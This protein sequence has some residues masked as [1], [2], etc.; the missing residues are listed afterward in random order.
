[1]KAAD[2]RKSSLPE[3]DPGRMLN[4][5]AAVTRK[6]SRKRS[7][8]EKR[9]NRGPSQQS[10]YDRSSPVS[11]NHADPASTMP[12]AYNFGN[13]TSVSNVVA[14]GS[15]ATSRPIPM[16]KKRPSNRRKGALQRALS[17]KS[18]RDISREQ[19]I[20]ALS[21]SV[22]SNFS[23][24]GLLGYL[25]SDVRPSPSRLA[26]HHPSNHSLPLQPS[27]RSSISDASDSYAY[28]VNGLALLAPRPT[29]K[30][31]EVSRSGTPSS[32]AGS[33]YPIHKDS[34]SP[35]DEDDFH[36]NERI[37]DL[38]DD[39]DAS[40]LRAVME[41]HQRRKEKK[42]EKRRRRQEQQ[43]QS[44]WRGAKGALT[45]EDPM[46]ERRGRDR[47]PSP[48]TSALQHSANPQIGSSEV[49]VN[50]QAHSGS[51]LRGPSAESELRSHRLSEIS[52]H[53]HVIGNI[54]D[55]SI[56]NGKVGQQQDPVLSRDQVSSGP[57]STDMGT[58]QQTQ[59]DPRSSIVLDEKR[60]SVASNGSR[61]SG[62][63]RSF[64][65]RPS[66]RKKSPAGEFN[67]EKVTNT[68]ME[69]FSRVSPVPPAPTAAIPIPGRS[70][71]RTGGT[72]HRPKSKFT[73]H[74]GDEPLSPPDSRMNS[75]VPP[76]L[77]P[78]EGMSR[79]ASS[80]PLSWDAGSRATRPDSAMLSQ[81]L[82]SID[83]EGSWMSGRFLRQ[84]SQQA[85]SQPGLNRRQLDKY[86]EAPEEE[87]LDNGHAR[88]IIRLGK[89]FDDADESYAHE[90]R[91]SSTTTNS[92]G[93]DNDDSSSL[94]DDDKEAAETWHHEGLARRPTLVRAAHLR[95]KSREGLVNHVN[96][97]D[98]T[99]EEPGA[100]EEEGEERR[101]RY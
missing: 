64:F 72:I 92:R 8:R 9:N 24:S 23:R 3:S 38:A 25:P 56:R 7:K 73:E 30:C 42:K 81:S 99:E 11:M 21:S 5:I 35:Y 22:P 94:G 63:L 27:A 32:F 100:E 95:A 80:R 15:F 54:D 40:G 18:S 85:S 82:A 101:R 87:D 77:D 37:A 48:A 79:E 41:R 78:Y 20:K 59:T 84:I 67:S 98:T 52:A 28:K 47:T 46:D 55:R 53:A 71:H 83:S 45:P 61:T 96:A 4:P 36:S 26:Q 14:E 1:M 65:R 39:L 19:Q 68:S 6:P 31:A 10:N 91:A 17:R 70:F 57:S 33:P 76:G 34:A 60:A 75:P 97:M 58:V 51:W 89:E 90:R 86:D 44:G 69:S 13:H 16:L 93:V 74:F 62:I 50:E 49:S 29:L 2:G 43:Q 66:A 12:F 88:S